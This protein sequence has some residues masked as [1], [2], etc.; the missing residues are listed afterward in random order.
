MNCASA[1]IKARKIN[2]CTNCQFQVS[3]EQK[4]DKSVPIDFFIHIGDKFIKFIGLKDAAKDT[5]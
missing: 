4:S 5:Y 2:L 3:F 1:N